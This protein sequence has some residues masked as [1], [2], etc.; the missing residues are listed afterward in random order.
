MTDLLK[1]TPSE[2][3]TRARKINDM[4]SAMSEYFTNELNEMQG[5]D[6]Q[7]AAGDA[8]KDMFLEARQSF[9]KVEDNLNGC[10]SLLRGIKDGF[11][12]MDAEMA[13]RVAAGGRA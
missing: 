1:M 4:V 5:T 8:F 2:L 6:W 3:E 7:G 13:R 10:A 9:R 11:Q 12:E